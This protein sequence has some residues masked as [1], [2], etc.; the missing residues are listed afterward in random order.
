MKLIYTTPLLASLLVSCENPADKTAS[1]KI[2]EPKTALIDKG[3]K[4]IFTDQSTIEFTGSKVTGSHS[5]GFKD[6]K[7][8]FTLNDGETSPNSGSI[9]IDMDSTY[10]DAEK[11]TGHLKSADFFDVE[12]FPTS[13]F[14][15][16]QVTE[17]GSGAYEI[18]GNFTLHGITKNISFPASAERNGNT[19]IVRAEFDINRKHFDI[20]YAGKSDD[21]IRDE[22][23]IRFN[24][25]AKSQ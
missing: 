5:G 23:V 25:E 8:Y 11:L 6:L 10:S 18:S 12:K 20:V 4:F 16:T 22:V 17:T 1:A 2:E 7:G 24:L 13:T 15:M 19:S 21:L 9:T 3:T 14:N